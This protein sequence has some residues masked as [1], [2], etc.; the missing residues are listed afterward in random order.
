MEQKATYIVLQDNQ[1][2]QTNTIYKI[3][4]QTRQELL[5][6][7]TPYITTIQSRFIHRKELDE[8]TAKYLQPDSRWRIYLHITL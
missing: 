4:T 6:L 7:A 8:V 1:Q 3:E 5:A 2:G